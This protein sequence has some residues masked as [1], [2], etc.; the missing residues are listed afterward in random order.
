LTCCRL[1]HLGPRLIRDKCIVPRSLAEDRRYAAEVGRLSA[2]LARQREERKDLQSQ[3]DELVKTDHSDVEVTPV[4]LPP[5]R[6][7]LA[8]RPYFTGRLP[9]SLAVRRL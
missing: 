9:I 6:F 7:R 5:G 8:A 1:D 3:I 2:G 4:T